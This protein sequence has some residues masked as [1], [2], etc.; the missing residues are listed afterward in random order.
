MALKR[1][2]KPRL[3]PTPP[4]RPAVNV[5][6]SNRFL[7]WPLVQ[8][9]KGPLRVARQYARFSREFATFKTLAQNRTERFP[10]RW[11]DRQPCLDD[12]TANTGFDRHYVF[13]TA[14]AARVLATTRPTKHVDVGSSLYFVTGASA[15]VPMEF[16]DFRPADLQLSNLESRFANLMALPF[17][18][19]EVASLSCMH[20]VEHVGLGRYGDPLDPDGDLKAMREL[21]RVVA[22]SGSL[23]LV[24]PVGR[25]CIRFNAHR[26][27][28][29]EQICDAFSELTIEQFSLIPD[30]VQE[31]GLIEDADPATVS[32]QR[33]ACGC[34]WFRRP[35][36]LASVLHSM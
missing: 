33:Y 16:Y 30:G 3:W 21:Q 36:T 8:F 18:D 12:R 1:L 19:Q 5:F 15:F 35:A 6:A 34:F 24:T 31:G 22:P 13:H 23:L 4:V 2:I 29:Y 28:S 11:E 25:P 17:G 32:K 14:W 26:I 7:M 10:L 9:N 20:V 27:Y